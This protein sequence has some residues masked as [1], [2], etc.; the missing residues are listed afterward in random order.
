MSD[1]EQQL[2]KN[3]GDTLQI[4]LQT[5]KCL[6]SLVLRF[7]SVEPILTEFHIILCSTDA[8]EEQFSESE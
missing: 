6:H 5:C 7:P 3:L 8:G 4:K 1:P 2:Q